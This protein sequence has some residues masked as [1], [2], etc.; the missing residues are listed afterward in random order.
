M[1]S[2]N[3]YCGANFGNRFIKKINASMSNTEIINILYDTRK[4]I[5][6]GDWPR[7]QNERQLALLMLD[8]NFNGYA[9]NDIPGKGVVAWGTNMGVPGY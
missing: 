8:S 7:N 5:K 4:V 6:N 3:I 1:F 2:C 9:A